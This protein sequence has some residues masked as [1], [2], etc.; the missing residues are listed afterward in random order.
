MTAPCAPG[1]FR[2]AQARLTHCMIGG[3]YLQ[4][5]QYVLD[6]ACGLG[7]TLVALAARVPGVKLVGLNIDRRQLELCRD[8]RSSAAGC[9]ALV[10]ADACVIPF[11]ASTFD[12][13]FCVEAMFH[14]QSRR[15]FLAE[16]AR[17]LR[18]GGAM[19]VSDIFLQ[20]PTTGSPW[21]DDVIAAILGR[22]YGPWPEP[23]IGVA[24]V[25]DWAAARDHDLAGSEDWTAQ[26][27]PSYRIV[28]P[29]QAPELSQHPDAGHVLRWLHT[30]G[31]LTYQRL[32]FRRR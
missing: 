21:D 26:T 31:Y 7:G 13:I 9:L 22:D 29:D 15:T 8:I 11:A 32:V 30:H 18:P 5:D 12:H 10:Q 6:V 4:P 14:F 1:E 2:A 16:A 23:W 20:R 17:L 3:A 24:N 25:L 27:L 19:H 28:A